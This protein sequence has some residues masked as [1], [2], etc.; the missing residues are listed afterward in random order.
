MD[1]NLQTSDDEGRSKSGY[2]FVP[3]LTG[4][5]GVWVLAIHNEPLPGHTRLSLGELVLR[6]SLDGTLTAVIK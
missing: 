3:S 1:L 4:N 2:R 6:G 5:T